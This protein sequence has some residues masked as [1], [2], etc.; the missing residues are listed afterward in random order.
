MSAPRRL[1]R[2]RALDLKLLREA[3]R[4]RAQLLSIASLV[5]CG[6]MAVIGMRST[7][8][9]VMRA[10]DEY[11]AAYRFAD[12]FASATRAPARLADEIARVPGVGAVQTR[13]VETVSL[14]VPGLDDAATGHLVS[15]PERR[16]SMLNDLH[17]RSGRYIQPG[18]PDEVL[19]S[20]VFA[21]KNHLVA[22]DSIAA[23]VNGRWRRLHVVGI[24]LSPE[25]IYEISAGGFFVDNRRFGILWMGRPAMEAA[26]D[27]KQAFNDVA[28]R[29]APGASR[30]AV[31]AGLDRILEPYGG[32]GAYGRVDQASNRVVEDEVEQ[33]RV[34]G[35]LFPLFF[36]G[37][38]AFLLNVVLSR[39]VTTQRDEIAIL[40]AFGYTD[41][42]VG[43]H[44]LGFALVAIAVGAVGGVAGGTWM[45][46]QYTSLYEDFFSF[47]ALRYRTG[48]DVAALAIAV[49][50][51]AAVTGALVA[52]RAAVRLPPAEA[53]R[54]E[55]PARYRPLLVERLGLERLVPPAARM[56][57]R[58]LERR[59]LRTIASVVGVGLAGSI[60]VAGL[61][62]YDGVRRLIHIQFDVTQREDVTVLFER[63][64]SASAGHD[65]GAI[66]GVR[67][68]ELFRASPVRLRHGSRVRLT[69]IT[70]LDGRGVLRRLVG[71]DGAAH[72]VPPVGLVLSAGLG[73]VLGVRVGDTVVVELLELGTASRRVPVVALHDE[74]IGG[75]AYMERGALNRL[76]H[77]GDVASGAYLALDRG[78]ERAVFA[79]LKRVPGV[80]GTMSRAA[81]LDNFERTMARSLRITVG[82]V[83]FAAS[84]IALGVVYNGAR[85]ALSER[86]REL[87]SLRVLGFTRREV[88]AILLGEQ[89]ALTAVSIPLG[90]AIGFAFCAL[91]AR[92]FATERHRFPLVVTGGTYVFAAA[93][94]L[95]AAALAGLSM[96]RRIN[97]LDLVAVLKTRV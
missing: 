91:L 59:P 52:I 61:Y 60:L 96:R 32:R 33:L 4:L 89:G 48:W 94:V 63:A 79:D 93:V 81:M 1:R 46:M 7:L 28:L 55:T 71:S 23:V 65:L 10:R 42:Q 37:V 29:L 22:G 30:P 26:F 16:E 84:A 86:G 80:A 51:A 19:L 36:L 25:F 76:L 92:A 77:E 3:W 67:T 12:V 17:L 31:L 43:A 62:P 45:G 53:M 58:N 18:H 72:P 56:V 54:P 14:D 34:M 47:P 87:A 2:L 78:A 21:R 40:K 75:A 8:G 39:L 49:S 11:Y 88:A 85:I 69:S 38:A 82:I 41:R 64:R 24:A 97:R 90:F 50:G 9:S 74:L 83:V 95:V 15:I 13:V 68:V 73:P 70:G 66:A 20:E 5:A 27:M 44:Y 6:A 35:D 57:L